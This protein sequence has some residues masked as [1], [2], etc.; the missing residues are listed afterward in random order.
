MRKHNKMEKFLVNYKKPSNSVKARC[1]NGNE[2]EL[3]RSDSA[4]QK[5]LITGAKRR[6]KSLFNKK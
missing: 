2:G 1:R 5:Q 3:A 6:T 4:Q